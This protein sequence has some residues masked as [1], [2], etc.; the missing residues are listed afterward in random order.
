MSSSQ[1]STV[2]FSNKIEVKPLSVN[3]AWQGKRFKS[4]KYE[5]YEKLLLFSLP[6]SKVNWDKI[7]IEVHLFIGFSNVAS[8]IDNAVK[9]FIDILQKRYLFND[10]F[11]FKLVVEKQIVSKG[12][13][14]IEYTIK[15]FE[16]I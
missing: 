10:K 3:E 13:E 2:I 11:I 16:K 15:K 1:K 9:P 12:K 6:P 4:K 8:D 7:P 5:A 14:F